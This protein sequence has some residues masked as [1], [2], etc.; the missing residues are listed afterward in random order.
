M[1]SNVGK[2]STYSHKVKKYFL[3]LSGFLQPCLYM[4]SAKQ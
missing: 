3:I 1:Q 4:L 2:N